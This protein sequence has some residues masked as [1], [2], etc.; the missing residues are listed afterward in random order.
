MLNILDLIGGHYSD[1]LTEPHV[2]KL[3]HAKRDLLM[4]TGNNNLL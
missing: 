4:V 2:F 1:G 3:W